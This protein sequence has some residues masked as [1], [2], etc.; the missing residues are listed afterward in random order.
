MKMEPTDIEQRVAIPLA[1]GRYLRSADRFNDASREFTGACKSLRKQLGS[2]QRFVVQVDF[3]HY[4]VTADRY[5]N[6]DVES[7]KSL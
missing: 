6:F 7:I 1:V 3:E 5:G 4:L 2:G